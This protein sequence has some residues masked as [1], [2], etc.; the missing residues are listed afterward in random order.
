MKIIFS[1]TK[2]QNEKS[3]ITFDG[4]LLQTRITHIL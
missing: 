1:P 3:E 4:S 2:S